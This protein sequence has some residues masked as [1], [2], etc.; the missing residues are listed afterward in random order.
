MQLLDVAFK[1]T[2]GEQ[3]NDCVLLWLH[4][5]WVMSRIRKFL[6]CGTGCLATQALHLAKTRL[7]IAKKMVASC[8]RRLNSDLVFAMPQKE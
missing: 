1:M 2:D 8:W 5:D 4:G 6:Q 7:V 3:I